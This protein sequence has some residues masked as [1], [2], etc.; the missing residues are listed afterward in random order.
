MKILVFSL[1]VI[2]KNVVQGGSQKV[3]R[4]ISRGLV[5]RGHKITIVCPR[6]KDN[7]EMFELCPGAVVKP[8]LPLREAFPMPYAVPPFSLVETYRLLEEELGDVDLL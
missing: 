5:Y 7:H 2:F 8:I 1:G 4:D 6:R 3:L